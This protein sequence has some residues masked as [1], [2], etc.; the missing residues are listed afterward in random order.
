MLLYIYNL[1][2]KLFLYMSVPTQNKLV[3]EWTAL[4]NCT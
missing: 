1:G 3:A 4:N 2:Y